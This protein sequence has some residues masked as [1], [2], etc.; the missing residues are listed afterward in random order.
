[1]GEGAVCGFKH[2]G[3][4]GNRGIPG[5]FKLGEIPGKGSQNSRRPEWLEGT[6]D[7]R[8]GEVRTQTF[9]VCNPLRVKAS[10]VF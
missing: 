6:E 4:E 5:A 9:R 3:R 7:R 10:L 2:E 1:M 8:K